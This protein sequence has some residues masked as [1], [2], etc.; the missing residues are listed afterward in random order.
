MVEQQEFFRFKLYSAQINNDSL[1]V[2]YET[3]KTVVIE[4]KTN[5]RRIEFESEKI[6]AVRPFYPCFSTFY[7]V[8]I[9]LHLCAA[10]LSK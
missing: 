8:Y 9:S 1:S 4:H 10:V 6:H 7:A 3:T 5:L 2:P